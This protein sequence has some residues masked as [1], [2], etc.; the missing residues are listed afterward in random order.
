MGKINGCLKCLFIFFN[1]IFAIVGCVLVYG[2]VKATAYSAQ[3]SAFGGPGLGWAWV[4]AIGVLGIS[5][6]GIYAACSEKPLALKIFAGFMGVGMLITM[7]FGIIMVVTR[8][9]IREQLNSA[10]A[11]LTNV[12]MENPDLKKTLDG[13]QE[14]AQCCGVM[15]ASD[16]GSD[17]PA[18]CECKSSYRNDRST[19]FS[20]GKCKARPQGTTGPAQIY[21]ESCS[22]FFMSIINLLFNILMG[23]FFACAVTALLGLLI[24]LLMIH[25]VRRHDN[26]GTASIAMKGY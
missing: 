1:V 5:C 21:E 4:F 23:F 25:Q 13:L 11:E 20:S 22:V 8:N 24:S 14:S 7:I 18:S 12:F 6:L 17:I 16:W 19:P 2:T 10:S 3:M 9:R 15:S 26:A